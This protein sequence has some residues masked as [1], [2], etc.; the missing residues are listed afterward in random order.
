MPPDLL[1][2]NSGAEKFLAA[3][4]NKEMRD[5]SENDRYADVCECS[6]LSYCCFIS[7]ISPI[8]G[9]IRTGADYLTK[10]QKKPD[11]RHG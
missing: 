11:I 8:E 10:G 5:I 9:L 2:T 3:H 6:A 1:K 7:H 4:V